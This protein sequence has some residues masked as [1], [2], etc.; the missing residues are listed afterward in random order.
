[1]VI[2]TRLHT[3]IAF[4]IRIPVLLSNSLAENLR[5]IK[6]LGYKFTQNQFFTH[7]LGD[8]PVMVINVRLNTEGDEK[9]QLDETSAIFIPGCS[10]ITRLA[11]ST[12]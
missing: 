4:K 8:W 2:V 10:L 5:K 12:R 7:S 11:S 1:M 6:K 9:P 3:L